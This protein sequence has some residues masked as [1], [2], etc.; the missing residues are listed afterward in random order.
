MRSIAGSVTGLMRGLERTECRDVA[1]QELWKRYN[2]KLSCYA[3]KRLRSMDG[4]R[5]VADEEDAAL[6]AFA[7]ICDKIK[8]GSLKLPSR[9]DFWRMLLK[10]ARRKAQH[11]IEW[12]RRPKRGG[13]GVPLSDS[14]LGRLSTDEL[15]AD[16]PSHPR[17]SEPERVAI[18]LEE[19]RRMLDILD[20]DTLR[21]IVLWRWIGRSNKEIAQ[22]LGDCSIQTVENRLKEIRKNWKMAYPGLKAQS[23]R[24]G[25]DPA[26]PRPSIANSNIAIA[27]LARLV[28]EYLI[29]L[30]D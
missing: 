13:A 3:L 22:E 27:V 28:R 17:L 7:T 5:T 29:D 21:K 30:T 24:R 16:H 23:G 11:Q 25:S 8:G 20:N 26:A 9:L 2:R 18:G 10:I 19:C 4:V 12:G 1:A 14:V 6:S 15:A